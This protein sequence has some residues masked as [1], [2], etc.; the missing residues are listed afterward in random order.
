LVGPHVRRHHL[1]VLRTVRTLAADVVELLE[2]V[3]LGALRGLDPER[4]VAARPTLPRHVAAALG[5]LGQREEAAEGGVG[6]VDQRLRNAV[7]GDAGKAPF[8]VGRAEFGDEAFAVAV[9]AADVEG[10]DAGGHGGG[11]R[12]LL[13]LRSSSVGGWWLVVGGW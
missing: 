8:A 13:A 10:G 11:L 5:F 4:R 3:V 2:V 12:G 1:A 9:E 7:V 6:I